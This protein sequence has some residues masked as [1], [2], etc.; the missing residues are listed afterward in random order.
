MLKIILNFASSKRKNDDRINKIKRRKKLMN[1]KFNKNE[2]E[3][4]VKA[5]VNALSDYT[6]NSHA[7][8]H[9]SIFI[10]HDGDSTY[11]HWGVCMQFA[12]CTPKSERANDKDMSGHEVRMMEDAWSEYWDMA[13]D[14]S[15]ENRERYA[16][17]IV[18]HYNWL[19]END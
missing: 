2:F 16:R 4:G 9:C 13:Y 1:E 17:A 3:N 6:P 10:H 14:N 5:V 11:V 7:D 15:A 12:N 19:A 8:E 18:E